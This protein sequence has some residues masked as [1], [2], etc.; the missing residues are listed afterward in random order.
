MRPGVPLATALAL[1]AAGCGGVRE[2]PRAPVSTAA[3]QPHA[4]APPAR[5][6]LAA[7]CTTSRCRGWS[8]FFLSGGRD[9]DDNVVAHERNVAFASRTLSLLGVAPT[10]QTTLF[11]DGG[12]P[13]ADVQLEEPDADRRPLLLALGL[14]RSPGEDYREALL[15][16]RDHE[17]DGA[18]M[19]N[20]EGVLAALAKDASSARARFAD[21]TESPRD[22]FF[23]VTD[24][25]L[26]RP[27]PTNNVIVLWGRRDLSVRELGR[28]LD[29]QPAERRVV[30]VMAQCYSG[31][32]ASLV[33]EGG[34]PSAQIARHDR[35]GFFAAPPDR[36]AAGCSPKADET[37]YDDYTTRFYSAVGGVDRSGRPTGGADL[38]GDGRV[39]FEEAHLSAVV[40]ERT[41][42]VPVTS[43]EELLRRARPAWVEDASLDETPLS[44]LLAPA[45]PVLR[46]AASTLLTALGLPPTVTV[47]ELHERAV[48]VKSTCWP[49]LCEAEDRAKEAR[50]RAHLALARAASGVTVPLRPASL[51]LVLLGRA[52]VEQWTAH[53]E[54][55]FS[56]AIR[57]DGEVERL[58]LDYETFEARLVRLARLAELALLERRVV[59][60]G[61]SLSA[62]YSRVRT[63]ETSGLWERPLPALLSQKGT[64]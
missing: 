37:L 1:L 38:D 17:L 31:S 35:C 47:R 18:G 21:G 3:E 22:L 60:E 24:H 51:A 23:Y 39:T 48:A 29:Q 42:D 59:E 44:A 34:D 28:S 32:F 7:S 33:H 25:G 4:V 13:E 10:W 64:E 52:R 15:R 61:S 40:N 12:D 57:L 41:Q 30:T 36:P 54:P 45:R 49:G 53:A 8:A 16:Y 14:L 19:A 6:I 63:C 27:D 9:R 11:G 46:M 62:T 2:T 58:R 50:T 26:K 43:S 55:H 56:E 5:R 20:H